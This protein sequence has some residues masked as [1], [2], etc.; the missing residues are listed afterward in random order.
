MEAYR[1]GPVSSIPCSFSLYSL[2]NQTEHVSSS[3][4]RIPLGEIGNDA[5]K[6]FNVE[7]PGRDQD[8][9]EEVTIMEEPTIVDFKRLLEL[10]NYSEKGSSRLAYLVK[11]WEYKEANAVRLLREEL[12]ILSKQREEVELKKLEILRSI[13][14][15]KKL[16]AISVRFPFLMESTTYGLMFLGLE[17]MSLFRTRELRLMLSMTLL[18]TGS[19]EPCIFL[20]VT[21]DNVLRRKLSKKLLKLNV[22]MH[23]QMEGPHF[24]V[25]NRVK[26]G[27]VLILDLDLGLERGWKSFSFVVKSV[28]L[29]SPSI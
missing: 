25:L 24:T 20:V 17:T 1:K 19:R 7:R 11:H 14:S 13:V 9:L 16:T 4:G 10:T 12:D 22:L 21:C 27:K 18:C 2:L 3:L 8:M 15:R 28:L 23:L 26:I 6:Q 29:E 5:G